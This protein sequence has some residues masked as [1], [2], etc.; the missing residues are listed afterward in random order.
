MA[1][2][3][4]L[5]GRLLGFMNDRDLEGI[6]PI[7]NTENPNREAD[8]VF[9]HGLGGASHATWQ[10][11]T[12]GESRYFFWPEEL[13][14][15]LPQCGIWTVGYPAGITALGRTGM[16][17]EKRAGNLAQKLANEKL[18]VRPIFFITHSMGGLIVKS[19]LVDS[20]TQADPD[21]KRIASMVSGIVFCATPHRGSDFANAAE[22]LSSFFGGTQDHVSEM[23]ANKEPLDFLHEKFIEWHR[24]HPI[25]IESYA[26]NI[27]LF[28]TRTLLRPVPLTLVVPRASANTGI[29]G[30]TVRDVDAD[31]LTIVKPPNRKNDVYAGVRRFIL[32]TLSAR[33]SAVQGNAAVTLATAPP[34]TNI[35][36]PLP[37][38]SK[39]GLTNSAPTQNTT[40]PLHQFPRGPRV[41][42]ELITH[43]FVAAYAKL[44]RSVPQIN[45]AIQEA[46][47]LRH[48]ADPDVPAVRTCIQ[49]YEVP[50]PG[51]GIGALE[52][53]Q[54]AWSVAQVKGPRM[55][56]ALLSL[57]DQEQLERP[58]QQDVRRLI[59]A[60]KTLS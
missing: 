27:G 21:R 34:A 4:G 12:V 33:T 17:I 40:H 24:H 16:I 30:H 36:Q 19:L 28:R 6:Y 46:N 60:M 35:V 31:H 11:G 3:K 53:W 42:D 57:I 41:P 48:A 5:I 29:P 50:E 39:G 59:G 52:F 22:I 51:H 10:H 55:V 14:K 32:E 47:D 20:Q 44:F 18:G 58:V 56:G 1:A 37:E 15:V 13:G 49:P 43:R 7:A 54:A 8:L 38:F 23:R 45:S 25:P 2:D 9:V 26:E